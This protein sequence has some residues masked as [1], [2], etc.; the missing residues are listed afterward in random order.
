MDKR[1]LSP[2][3]LSPAGDFEKLRFAAHYGADA[4]YLAGKAF[5]MR[6]A[7]AN[8]ADGELA[9][10]VKYAHGR[11][12]KVYITVNTLPRNGE[13]EGLP[14]FLEQIAELKADGVILSDLGVLSLCK[15]YAPEIPVHTSTQ[16]SVVNFESAR[17]WHSLGAER[18]VLARELTLSEIGE[19]RAKTPKEL[20]LEAF[21]HGAMCVSY[22]GRCL[23]SQYMAYRDPNRG[24]CAQACRWKYRLS[25]ELRPGK[26]MPVFEDDS[27][28]FIFNSRDLCMIRHIPE[29][30]RAGIDSFKIEGRVKTAYYVAAVTNAYRRAI[31]L[32]K[33]DPQKSLPDELFNEV[34][35]V[36]HRA[37][38]TGFYFDGSGPGEYYESPDPIREWDVA[39]VVDEC[40][41][42]NLAL[43]TQKNRFFVGDTLELLE[44]GVPAAEVLV[45]ELYDE[46][47]NPIRSAPHPQMKIMLRLPRKTE[48]MA[49][50]RRKRD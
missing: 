9:A 32:Y 15:K 23:L 2:E 42:E 22:S 3:L 16:A 44:P 1:P 43:C 21:V 8:F 41:D 24:D 28:T 6:R 4:V 19:I 45:S 7:S 10:A 14:E 13:I 34:N 38:G 39:A 11:G 29:L 48:P 33:S 25:E 50:L 20:S 47:R 40:N 37:Y 35:K 36:S 18:V 26:Y 49:I 27:G 5:G 30:L 12:V 31:D 17:M 46:N